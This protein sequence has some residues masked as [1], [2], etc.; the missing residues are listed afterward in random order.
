M[1]RAHAR[2]LRIMKMLHE[3]HKYVPAVYVGHAGQINVGAQQVNVSMD[4]DE[5]DDIR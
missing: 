3:V 2:F 1:E 4:R 5:D